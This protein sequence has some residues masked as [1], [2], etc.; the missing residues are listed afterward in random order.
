MEKMIEP[1]VALA[2]GGIV[3][4]ILVIAIPVLGL[5]ILLWFLNKVTN[6]ILPR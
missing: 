4:F 5:K 6:F 2:A 3:W 1:L